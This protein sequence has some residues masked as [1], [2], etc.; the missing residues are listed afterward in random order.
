[1]TIKKIAKLAGV[2]IGTVDRVLHGRG[3]VS[4][5][6]ELK[7]KKIIKENG[8]KPNIF[9]SNLSLSKSY[10]FGVIMPN[11]HQD[12]NYWSITTRGIDSAIEELSI[13]NISVK[14][15][16]FDKHNENSFRDAW[17]KM[18][19][20]KIDGLLIAPVLTNISKYYIKNE[21]PGNIHISFFDTYVPDVDCVSYIGQDSYQSGIVSAK[22][23]KMLLDENGD[24]GIIRVIPDDFHI[25]ERV[26][27]FRSFFE[28]HKDFNISIYDIYNSDD[29]N[30][31][32]SITDRIIKEN[33][34]KLGI[35]VTNALTHHI[36]KKI[37]L[38]SLNKKIFLIGYDLIEK[39]IHFLYNGII[40][41]LINQKPEDQGYQGIYTLYRSI[42]LK[43]KINKKIMMPI[44]IIMNENIK[45]YVK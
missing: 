37:N 27:G 38:L 11:K 18:L 40:D 21:L 23:M 9:A 42:V 39:N 30:E 12:S 44:D 19:N 3:R 10:V 16:Y 41:F 1:M 26:K 4:K 2:S 6:T 36:A 34:S 14:Y 15:F 8:Y 20:T 28:N 35:F 25:N 17:K 22:L 32:Y 7:I 45:Y 5:E 13:Y 31:F 29:I 33:G 43:E 24:I